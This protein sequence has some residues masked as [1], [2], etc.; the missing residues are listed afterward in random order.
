[1]HYRAQQYP[2]DSQQCKENVYT[3]TY[4]NYVI[5]SDI[6]LSVVQRCKIL[7]SCFAMLLCKIE[8]RLLIRHI[9]IKS[10]LIHN[11]ISRYNLFELTH[12]VF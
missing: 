6:R 11:D 2:A 3:G 12:S 1:M 5:R 4:N 7:H 10:T 8:S 9:I